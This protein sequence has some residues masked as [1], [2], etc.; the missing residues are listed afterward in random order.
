MKNFF[1]IAG[2][3]ALLLLVYSLLQGLFM[4]LALGGYVIYGATTETMEPKALSE[5]YVF[6]EYGADAMSISLFLSCE[7]TLLYSQDTL[8]LHCLEAF[9]PVYSIGHDCNIYIQCAGTVAAA[10]ES[11]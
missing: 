7:E 9:A 4:I 1:K 2:V 3:V 11:S 5:I 10:R 8:H 6:K